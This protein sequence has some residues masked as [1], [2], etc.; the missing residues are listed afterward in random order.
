[1]NSV[2]PAELDN[3]LQSNDRLY[4]L[5]IRPEERYRR[6]AIDGSDNLPVYDELRGG[7]DGA[8]LGQL[9]EIPPD[10]EVVVV[11]KMGIV[12]KRAATLLDE[13]GYDATVLLGGMSGWSGYQNNTFTYKLRSLLWK[14]R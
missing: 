2:A 10:R 13:E 12:A 9:G 7:D 6:N 5:D 4:V 11:C 3:R 1:M 14:L 8:L